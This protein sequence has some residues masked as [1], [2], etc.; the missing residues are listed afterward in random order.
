MNSG[1]HKRISSLTKQLVV[2]LGSMHKTWMGA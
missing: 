2:S 1:E